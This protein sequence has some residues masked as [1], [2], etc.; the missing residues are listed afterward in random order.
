MPH[1][2][3]IKLRKNKDVLIEKT[4]ETNWTEVTEHTYRK[5]ST[6]QIT[7]AFLSGNL[8]AKRQWNKAFKVLKEKKK[9][10]QPRSQY[11]LKISLRNEGKGKH[12][13]TKEN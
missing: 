1:F 11:L 10:S 2:I 3:I 13:H 12:F 6:I 5:E 8:E 4:S 9:K 7:M